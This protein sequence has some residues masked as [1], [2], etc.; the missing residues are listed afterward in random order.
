MSAQLC[1]R[2]RPSGVIPSTDGLGLANNGTFVWGISMNNL[3]SYATGGTDTQWSTGDT[4]NVCLDLAN[5]PANALGITNIMAAIQDGDLDIRFQDDT[6]VDWLQVIVTSCCS[7]C[8]EIVGDINHDGS[9][10]D[11]AD[12]VYLVSFM[13]QGGPPPPCLLE[14]DING[15]GVGPDISDLVWLVQYMFQNGPAPVPCP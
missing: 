10:P 5:L 14:A 11:I 9:G 13:F 1:L 7:N 15:D 3:Q 4:M 12:L 2:V 6:E 8:C